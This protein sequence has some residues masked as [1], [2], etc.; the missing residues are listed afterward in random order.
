MLNNSKNNSV[1]VMESPVENL[2]IETKK[3]NNSYKI[4]VDN[5]Y[6]S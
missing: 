2:E 1:P 6:R 5:L 3:Q 4:L